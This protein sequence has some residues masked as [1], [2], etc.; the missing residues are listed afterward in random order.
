LM[1]LKPTDSMKKL[2][3]ILFTITIQ[4][5]F[6]Q[7]D[8]PFYHSIVNGVSYDTVLSNLI[9]LQNLGVKQPGSAA[10]TNTKNWLISK[11]QAFG[12]TDIVQSN[13]TYWGQNLTNIVVTKTGTVYPDTY[14]IVDG[15]YDTKTGTGTN[16]N[17]SG[18]SVILEIARLMAAVPTKYS[19]RFINFS[20]E[21]QGLVGS[22]DYVTNVVTPQNMDILLV[23][24]IDEVGG[25][26]G[27]V[28]NTI[29]CENDQS[30]PTANNA[31][32]ALFT[33]TLSQATLVY[34]GLS[35]YFSNAYGSDYVPFQQAGKI[36]TGF[37][38]NNESS[39]PHSTGDNLAHLD[40]SYVYEVAKAATGA[41][42]Y[43]AKAYDNTTGQ[44]VHDHHC[45]ISIFPNPFS[46]QLS[47]TNN[48]AVAQVIHI[49]DVN[50]RQVKNIV[51]PASS[52]LTADM[53]ALPCGVYMIEVSDTRLV[54]SQ[55]L[56]L[57]K[58]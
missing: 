46:D 56:K 58:M 10:L 53:T 52:S 34:S 43:F 22:E 4:S 39:Y 2:I 15:H 24:N 44:T 40:T 31:V 37:Y 50:G 16:D 57:V 18:V 42:L 47:I 23:F 21:E 14:L 41:A 55:R 45:R 12:Y 9:K 7:L 19:V 36:I 27:Q 51:L 20:A 3:L 8:N 30:S 29:T 11:Y 17:G 28:N 32:S 38:E 48:D 25:V 35:T 49:Y 33:D 6:A 1:L 13:F 54:V 26:A 5:A